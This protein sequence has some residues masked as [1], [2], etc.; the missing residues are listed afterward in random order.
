M[1]F[2]NELLSDLQ[3][4][5]NAWENRDLESFLEALSRYAEG[6]DGLYVNTNQ[7]VDADKA[8]WKVIADMFM[9]ARIYE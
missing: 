7:N 9:G 2:L 6:I 3:T 8:S 1:V 4:N 5:K